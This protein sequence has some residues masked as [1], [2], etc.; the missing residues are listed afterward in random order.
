MNGN[1]S[2]NIA[3]EGEELVIRIGVKTLAFA[4]ERCEANQPFDEKAND[5]RRSWK[6]TNPHDFAKAVAVH[7]KDEE[8]DGSTKL[9]D[10]LD[11]CGMTAVEDA[12]GIDEDGRIVTNQM[13][14]WP[15]SQ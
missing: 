5:F 10:L 1:Q 4:F 15:E 12:A 8:E 3:V 6:V 11:E 9:T 14:D 2:L 13:L 7:L